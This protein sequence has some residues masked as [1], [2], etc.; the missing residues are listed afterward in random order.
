[1]ATSIHREPLAGGEGNMMGNPGTGVA[2]D[3]E[4]SECVI[5]NSPVPKW[6]R[7]RLEDSL[8]SKTKSL[9][10]IETRLKEADLRRQQFHEW[11]VNKARPKRRVSPP[12]SDSEDLAQRLEAKLSAAEHKRAELQAQEHMR[13]ARIHELRLAAKTETHL[14]M[15]RERE[16]LGC[17][18]ESRVH[19]A[20]TNRLALLEL[21]KQR[22]AAAH[23]RSA[24]SA[25]ARTNQEGKDRERIEAL[26]LTICQKIAAAEEKRAGL[27]EAGKCRAQ[28]TVLQARRVA[29]EV[30][31][32]RELERR[33]KREKLEARLQRARRQRAE[34]LQKRGGCKNS[35]QQKL[36]Q[37]DRLCRKLTRC[38]RQFRQSRSTTYELAQNYAACG[39]HGKSVTSISF[40]ELASRI[41]APT[42]LKIVKALLARMESRLKLSLDGQSSTTT[43]VDSLLKHVS[44][45]TRKSRPP[46]ATSLMIRKDKALR[47]GK[48]PPRDPT[49]S[50][51]ASGAFDLKNCSKEAAAETELDRYPARVFLCAYMIV[52]QPEGVF[53]SGTEKR[54]LALSEAAASLLPE[55]E[56]LM[57]IILDGP[58]STPA[59]SS[60]PNGSPQK[61]SRTEW[62]SETTAPAPLPSSRPFAAQLA[63]F[64]A[65][66]CAYLYHFVAWKVK[67][68]RVLEEEMTR[69]ACQLEVSMLLKCKFPGDVVV[70]NP[71][72]QVIRT[73]VLQDQR[74]LQDRIMHLTGGAGV[75]RLQE[76]LRDARTKHAQAVESG[77]PLISPF[78]TIT[79]SGLSTDADGPAKPPPV[80]TSSDVGHKY[81]PKVVKPQFKLPPPI[82]RIPVNLM[83]EKGLETQEFSPT[84]QGGELSNERIV[85]E[86]LH[87]AKWQLKKGGPEL[88]SAT[89]RMIE[90]QAQVRTTME[91][92]FWD[93]I[94]ADLAQKPTDYKRFV[95]LIGE[96]REE[97]EALVPEG[98]R[99][100]LRECMDLELI[101]QIL[102]SGSNDVEHLQ[103]LLDYASGLISKLGSPTRDS[104]ANSAAHESLVKESAATVSSIIKDSDDAFFT[105]IVKGL[106]FIFEQLQGLKQDMSATRLRAL[107]PLISGTAGVEYMRKSFATR[108][109]LETVVAFAEITQRLPNTL[110]W[111]TEGL[112]NIEHEKAELEVSLALVQGTSAIAPS[113]AAGLPPLSS[114]R[115][116]GRI[117]VASGLT[118]AYST[119]GFGLHASGGKRLHEVEWKSNLTLVYLGLLRILRCNEP[120]QEPW[121]PETLALNTIRLRDCQNA[122]QRILVIA[123]GLLVARQG[124][125]TQGVAP[126]QLE[127]IMEKGKQKL[128]VL[129][130]DPTASLTQIGTILAEI[131]NRG[132]EVETCSAPSVAPVTAELMT[133]VLKKSLSPEDPVFARVSAT[134]EASLRALLI[135][136]KS[137]EGMACAQAAL[138]R[139]GG[140]YLMDKVTATAAALEVLAEV[141][142]RVHEPWYSCII[143]AAARTQQLRT[144][145]IPAE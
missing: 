144:A 54:E 100:E 55:F 99:D 89:K 141:T 7:Q 139:I 98:W 25:V 34:F 110:N 43:S 76:A 86:M 85:N 108:Y 130:N 56:V 67:D 15:E 35:C 104:T 138:K 90:T 65:A 21:D 134:V 78:V 92:A 47:A 27:I 101:A 82:R 50:P 31:R 3:I 62:P 26:R 135:L 46:S 103:R 74:L 48:L 117:G 58:T 72:V 118:A 140:V 12:H 87:D 22:R 115:T 44:L 17:K 70:I 106:R 94:T 41:T 119:A 79:G 14:R 6:L 5:S 49:A 10:E 30:V 9:D 75:K 109:Q 93:G 59:G 114:M 29:Q 57:G 95:S 122:F 107:V 52:G 24:H 132:D 91:N 64:D 33:N 45:P 123:T 36:Q 63:V 51:V 126:L 80:D 42:T 73:Q 131:A 18:V 37:G 53:S 143:A 71:D 145:A 112:Q 136:G 16:E 81:D 133:R 60:S 88:S 40:E 102:E 32:E 38:W 137:S 11:L 128:E 1:M 129:L 68:A 13:L 23:E 124:L 120:A 77:A 96:A 8:E 113:V 121:V 28:A 69:M 2:F 19:Q 66:W 83:R 142:C 105:T 97:L 116:G 61:R 125:I 127:V 111:F 84:H 20:E 39:L 4:I